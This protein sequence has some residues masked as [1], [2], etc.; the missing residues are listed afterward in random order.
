[1]MKHNNPLKSAKNN[2][3]IEERP[4]QMEDLKKGHKI[5]SRV[6]N[7]VEGTV[8]ETSNQRNVLTL[9]ENGGINPQTLVNQNNQTE[10][11]YTSSAERAVS[12]K[13]RWSAPERGEMWRS[14]E[15]PQI[16]PK[17]SFLPHQLKVSIEGLS[18]TGC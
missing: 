5:T 4:T 17:F 11:T 7:S 8:V 12:R 3:S 10:K 9:S 15:D 18:S 14:Q 6:E 16:L 1:M 2:G 13:R